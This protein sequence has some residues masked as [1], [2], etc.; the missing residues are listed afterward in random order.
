MPQ[1]AYT[2]SVLRSLIEVQRFDSEISRLRTAI[3]KTLK[4]PDVEALRAKAAAAAR[5]AQTAKDR[6]AKFKHT[7]A[8]EEKESDGIRAEITGSERKMYGGM[9]AN[10]K[11]LASMG[12]RVEQLRL[13]LGR[14]DEAGLAALMELE[15]AEPAQAKA[16][17]LQEEARAILAVTEG[18]QRERVA[19]LEGELA[20]VE[21]R[22]VE[23]APRVPETLLRKY[24]RIRDTH[25]GVGAGVI[26]RD[27]L[28]GSCLVEVPKALARAVLDGQ[29]E[30]CETCGRLL[31]HMFESSEPTE[32]PEAT[33]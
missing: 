18:K 11:E 32:R 29:L 26:R 22:R 6:V 3:D 14:H 9:I 5:E 31:I 19:A 8:F 30:T 17:R 4:D 25:G 7:V 27:G 13:D 15:E 12:E 28:C 33:E 23:F 21:P 24:E 1:N 10:P 16:V 2:R 20:Q